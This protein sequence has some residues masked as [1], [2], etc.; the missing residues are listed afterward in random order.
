ME[1]FQIIL[2]TIAYTIG[3]ITITLQVICYLREIEYKETLLLSVS[4]LLLIAIFAFTKFQSIQSPIVQ[5]I[6]DFL[7]SF[8][9][10]LLAV[11]IPLNIHK[12]REIKQELAKNRVAI[13]LGIT[14]LLILILGVTFDFFSLVKDLP[15]DLLVITLIY[16]MI[17]TMTSQP[18]LLIKH[19][20]K[21]ERYTALFFLTIFPIY[22]ILGTLDYYFQFF[23]SSLF[24]G[25]ISISM[26]FIGIAFSKLTDDIKRLTL[27][28][29]EEKNISDT[30]SEYQIS[31]REE[32][33]IGLL[34]QGSSYREIGERL[35]ISLPTVKTHVSN[36]YRKMKVRNKVELINLLN[37]A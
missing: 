33:V 3:I 31:P 18:S 37:E 14:C 23:N 36:I 8:F 32:E 10:L 26:I 6:L 16:S 12:E 35:F 1:I 20:E 30:V 4:F 34:L 22:I 13:G 11:A 24:E 28:T 29:K 15:F 27:F 9:A 7:T 21:E 25:G 5:T 2:F 19:R 17:I